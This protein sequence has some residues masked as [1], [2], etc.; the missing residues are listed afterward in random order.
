MKLSSSVST[1]RITPTTQLNSRG[2]LYDPVRKTRNMCSQTAITMPC[3]AH[4][5]MFRISIPNGMS[6][7]R[8]FM[9]AY[10]YCATGR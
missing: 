1:S 10:A 6:N 5:C 4:R 8:Y 7:S 9:S 2:G 3:A